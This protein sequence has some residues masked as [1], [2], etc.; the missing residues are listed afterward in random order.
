MNQ[1][2]YSII[3]I[4]NNKRMYIVFYIQM[5]FIILLIYNIFNQIID[6]NKYL[7]NTKHLVESNA[8]IPSD[9][10]STEQ[11]DYM[12]NEDKNIIPKLKE[13]YSYIMSNKNIEIYSSYYYYLQE[14]INGEQVRFH[15]INQNFNNIISLKTI[16]GR[17]FED[18][19]FIDSKSYIPILI[20]Y[21]LK[22]S[23]DVGKI[24]DMFDSVTGYPIKCKVI[25]I[26]EY[27]S[28][29][30]SINYGVQDYLNNS[31]ISPIKA[32]DISEMNDFS[33]LDLSINNSIIITDN[34]ENLRDI[35][36]KSQNLNLFS[37]N[38]IPLKDIVE[39]N[40]VLSKN[41]IYYTLFICIIILIFS[42]IG[43]ITS[44][45]SLINRHIHDFSIHILCGAR[46]RNI[47]F[48]ISMEI[49][50][51]ETLA[52]IPLLFFS[53]PNLATLFT[54]LL[55]FIIDILILIFPI[56]KLYDSKIIS[57]IKRRQ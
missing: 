31:I 29:F 8:Y 5:I 49:L 34:I 48:R 22:D 50:L 13:L 28:S 30:I 32:K 17:N 27:N 44:L 26:L 54:I 9:K 15:Y 1:I 47:I 53:T 12:M 37:I 11:L 24:Y 19:D 43:I 14:F 4:K 57:M 21:N 6:S 52:L 18:Y 42:L 3:D 16:K 10:T 56:I 46:I 7:K 35:E 33:E 51:V 40:L 39:Q 23:Y 25:G 20:G 38:Y 45:L 2:R 41:K 36:K 55:I